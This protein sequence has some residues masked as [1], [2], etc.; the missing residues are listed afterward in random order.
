MWLFLNDSFISIVSDERRPDNLLIRARKEGDIE[1]F[2]PGA[3]AQRTPDAD[4][5]YRA[6]VPRERVAAALAERAKGIDYGNFKGSVPDDD[7][8]DVYMRVW[9]AMWGWQSSMAKKARRLGRA[10]ADRDY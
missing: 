10:L 9:Q 6:S 3:R 7:R 8:H 1:A 4:Y 2:I 5:L